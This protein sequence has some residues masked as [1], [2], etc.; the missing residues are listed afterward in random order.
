MCK[1]CEQIGRRDFMKTTGLASGAALY[2]LTSSTVKA[3]EGNWDVPFKH[4]GVP[5]RV[6]PVLLYHFHKREEGGT[7]R[8]WGGLKTEDD[9]SRE[10]GRI[11]KELD[12]MVANSGF[13][14]EVLPL[15]KVN[16]DAAAR[17]VSEADCD[18]ILLYAA[19]S[20]G[21][22]VYKTNRIDVISNSGKPVVM[23]LR[24][25]SGPVYLWYEIAHPRLLRGGTD[26][27]LHKHMDIDD[28][29]VDDY[30][31]VAWRL[32]ALYGLK[33]IKQTKL[34]AVNG[35]G[36]WGEGG[37][38]VPDV[39]KNVW[40]LQADIVPMEEVKH[41]MAKKEESPDTWQ[42]A[43]AESDRY[44][45]QKCILSVDTDKQFV[46]RAFLL[47]DVLKELMTEHD[48]VGVTIQ[49]CMGIGKIAKTTACLPFSLINDEG[50]MA[51]CESDFVVIPSGI[52]LR[53]M[54]G[55]PVF[56]NDP[57]LPHNGVSTCAHCSAPRRMDGKRFE[58]THIKTHCESDYGAAPKV[59]FSKGQLITNIVP[60]FHSKHWIGFR[61]RITDHP[62]YDICRSQ[63][64]C[65]IEGNWKTVLNEMRGFHW[66]TCYGDYLDEIGYVLKKAGI[67]WTN[68]SQA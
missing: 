60:D 64:D 39:I 12:N 28:I 31:S 22:R 44:L 6:K 23:F 57:C 36:G 67:A 7:W 15:A 34:V 25:K 38:Y 43:V 27:F 46:V 20:A 66:M 37:Q 48:A 35:V 16:T 33:N 11:K 13:P 68:V 40:E 30:Q 58:E 3:A 51:F 26:A 52:L 21:D 59:N 63:F 5:L 41:R 14:L 49:G 24:H 65:E 55:K 62:C 47:R 8:E 2:G 42:K 9:V 56:L 50:L 18:V 4:L 10:I 29:V 54:S 17:E 61:A 45:A 1:C 19:G 32:R 53:Y